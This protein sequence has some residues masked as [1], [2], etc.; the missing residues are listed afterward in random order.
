MHEKRDLI[1]CQSETSFL[2]KIFILT[3]TFHFS[4]AFKWLKCFESESFGGDD[5]A[6]LPWLHTQPESGHARIVIKEIL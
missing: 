5:V 1:A 3:M 4:K 6:A 2:Y